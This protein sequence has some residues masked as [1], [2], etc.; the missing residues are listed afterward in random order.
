[1]NSFKPLLITV[2]LAIAFTQVNTEAIATP[3]MKDTNPDYERWASFSMPDCWCYEYQHAG[4]INGLLL[5]DWYPVTQDDLT[6]FVLVYM[7]GPDGLLEEGICADLDH[8]ALYGWYAVSQDDLAIIVA[9]FMKPY[10]DVIPK[11]HASHY[12]FFITP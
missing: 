2:L 7:E 3:C 6:A 10:T 11:P 9:N 4:D 1:M 8:E 5:Y 12:N